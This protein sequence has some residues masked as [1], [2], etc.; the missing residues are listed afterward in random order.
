MSERTKGNGLNRHFCASKILFQFVL[1]F[2]WLICLCQVVLPLLGTTFS[3]LN[4][5]FFHTGPKRFG[6]SG[7]QSKEKVPL[8]V[9]IFL[10]SHL[11]LCEQ[12]AVSRMVTLQ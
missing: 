9:S 6:P 5:F 10:L 11:G 1:F 3:I 2:M 4:L 8:N 7:A 12:S